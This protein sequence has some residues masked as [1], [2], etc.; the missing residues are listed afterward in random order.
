LLR[1]WAPA[2]ALAAVVAVA[3]AP[4][5]DPRLLATALGLV[6]LGLAVQML[7]GERFS[8][9]GVSALGAAGAAAAA[10]VGFLAAALGVGA[11]TLGVPALAAMRY[12]IKPAIGTTAPLTLLVA[13]I[14]VA[15]FALAG[16]GRSDL[17]RDAVGFVELVPAGLLSIGAIV[18]APL[19]ARLSVRAPALLLRRLFALCL[20]VVAVRMLQRAW[21]GA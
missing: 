18:A 16:F 17:P 8:I 20:A 6:A 4:H 5:A 9:A 15:G 14:G 1:T 3:V 21:T 19:G 11:G 2:T 10:G 7:G 13:S 12:P